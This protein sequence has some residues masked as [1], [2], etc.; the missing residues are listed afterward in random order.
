MFA[1]KVGLYFSLSKG[2]Q[3]GSDLFD[4]DFLPFLGSTAEKRREVTGRGH[5]QESCAL[6]LGRPIVF[7]GFCVAKNHHVNMFISNSVA[8]NTP[9]CLVTIFCTH[10]TTRFKRPTSYWDLPTKLDRQ[11]TTP[12]VVLWAI[13]ES[14]KRSWRR[15]GRVP[16]SLP[17][18]PNFDPFFNPVGDKNW[19]R[20]KQ[21]G[22]GQKDSKSFPKVHY[23]S[24]LAERSSL[25]THE[26]H[27]NPKRK[28]M[29]GWLTTFRVELQ[30]WRGSGLGF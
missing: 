16:W 7:W 26:T 29:P 2:P 6:L 23:L 18:S 5:V 19:N 28:M 1:M 27:T 3:I 21:T 13:A 20:M 25:L 11:V 30:R 15:N 24:L 10:E 14:T 4:I 22:E 9:F 8:Y 17:L 12:W